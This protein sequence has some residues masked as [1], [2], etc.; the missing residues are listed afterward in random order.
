MWE[1]RVYNPFPHVLKRHVW[2]GAR[3]RISNFIEGK[4]NGHKH[5]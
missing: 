2:G 1:E 5:F 3:K 4:E